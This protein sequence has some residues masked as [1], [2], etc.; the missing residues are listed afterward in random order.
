MQILQ[1][2]VCQLFNS[3]SMKKEGDEAWQP[4]RPWG[5]KSWL[6]TPTLSISALSPEIVQE[7]ARELERRDGRAMFVNDWANSHCGSCTK[8]LFPRRKAKLWCVCHMG[9]PFASCW[10][11]FECPCVRTYVKYFQIGDI[12]KPTTLPP[13]SNATRKLE[14]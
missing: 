12:L 9:V 7:V 3:A 8:K 4:F 1:A 14:Y 5:E 2:S 10:N 13:S 6:S 11:I